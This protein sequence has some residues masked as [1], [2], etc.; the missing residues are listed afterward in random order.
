MLF[1][2]VT[3]S[4]KMDP[5]LKRK[6]INEAYRLFIAK[7]IRNTS[8]CDVALAVHKSKGAVIH[9]FPSKR[10][11]VDAVIRSRFFPASKLT[12]EMAF[13]P[14]ENWNEFT[15]LY[16]NPIERAIS[17]FPEELKENGLMH[18]LQFVSSAGEY[19]DEFSRLYQELLF[20]EQNFLLGVVYKAAREHRLA[21][22]DAYS[23]S[24]QFFDS[25]IGK[26]FLCSL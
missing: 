10:Q 20:Q 9:H 16:R 12:S 26:T 2:N 19:M 8:F 4:Y 14:H 23:F 15:L 21:V 6:I 22:H 18:Y 11:L 13:G 5:D 25:S 7:G 24:R 17:D 1:F 3:R